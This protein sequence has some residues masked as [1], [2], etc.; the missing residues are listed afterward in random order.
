MGIDKEFGSGL[1]IILQYIGKHVIDFYKLVAATNEPYEY[2]Q[3]KL[4]RLISLQT[5]ETTHSIAFR[6]SMDFIHETMR[7]EVLGLYNFTTEELFLRPKISYD[8]ADAL[9]FTVGGN[10]YS[11][12]DGTLYDMISDHMN[13]VFIELKASF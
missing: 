7:T 11:G 8:I 12:I 10:F 3:G 5:N 4:N 13:G 9:T 6:P 1:K 2:Q